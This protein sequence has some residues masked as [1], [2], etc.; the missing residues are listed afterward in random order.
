M[1]DT[2]KQIQ[3]Y[4]ENLYASRYEIGPDRLDLM[5]DKGT[6]QYLTNKTRDERMY[7]IQNSKTLASNC[8]LLN[9]S[10]PFFLLHDNPFMPK[11]DGPIAAQYSSFE[12]PNDA[13]TEDNIFKDFGNQA[14]QYIREKNKQDILLGST[15]HHLDE[16]ADDHE[17]VDSDILMQ[18]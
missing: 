4:F 10:N 12:N 5:K 16:G 17:A 18:H 11:S 9:S 13:D 15:G 1:D 2:T 6:L 8:H 7:R 3:N 14:V